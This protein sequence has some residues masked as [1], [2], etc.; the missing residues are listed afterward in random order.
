MKRCSVCKELKPIIEYNKNKVRKD[1]LQSNCRLCTQSLSRSYY[2]RNRKAH[3]QATRRRS[4]IYFEQRMERL[5]EYLEAHHC[6]D[7][8]ETDPV[9]LEFDHI[10]G[11]KEST[12]SRM[13]SIRRARSWSSVLKEIA[14]CEVRCA[15][16]HRRITYKRSGSI[17]SS[18][19]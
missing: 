17:R 16:C 7:C 3:I 14:K 5:R 12:I 19:M 8:G 9:V 6:V 10:R 15:N 4:R 11:T 1:G 13:V 18:W 2:H